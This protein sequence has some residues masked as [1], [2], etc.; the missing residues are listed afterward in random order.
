MSCV[1]MS[2]RVLSSL[3]GLEHPLAVGFVIGNLLFGMSL[4][5]PASLLGPVHQSNSPV[6]LAARRPFLLRF[7]RH[8]RSLTLTQPRG[9]SFSG[10]ENFG[11]DLKATRRLAGFQELVKHRTTDSVRFAELIKREGPSLNK[12]I[13]FAI[14]VSTLRSCRKK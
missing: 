8:R 4:L 2:G 14:H 7:Y 9:S 10:D 5:T 6:C 12:K 1:V 11:A 3:L 13:S